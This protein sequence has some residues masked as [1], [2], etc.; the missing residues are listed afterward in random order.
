MTRRFAARALALG[1]GLACSLG[2]RCGAEEYRVVADPLWDSV[3]LAS[4]LGAAA[5][6]AFALGHNDGSYEMKDEGSLPAI[7]G[8]GRFKYEAGLS[9][10]SVI[11]GGIAV[12]WP[13]FFALSGDRD[14]LVP[15]A[16]SCVEALTWTSATK[17][18][19][20]RLVPKARPYMYGSGELRDDL[21]DE[22]YESFPSGHTAL[23]FCAA[24]SF[25]VLA[26]K[27]AADRP[28]TP[29]LVGGG[30]VAATAVGALRMA[31]GEHFLSDVAAGALLGSA[32]GYAVTSL[33]VK[34]LRAD[35]SGSG[36]GLE[37]S[38]GA[39]G[40]MLILACRY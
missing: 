27:R 30:Y 28:E 39:D 13:A 31:A 8:L 25:A 21:K 17:D 11:A 26:T 32:I 20:K 1:L 40:P 34:P 12:L 4:G 3:T 37:A 24:T 22:A 10:A 2:S 7:E 9:K 38:Y 29:W 33:H 16:L 5:I 18:C 23:A 35:D 14:E 15:A 36:A 6:G 19:I